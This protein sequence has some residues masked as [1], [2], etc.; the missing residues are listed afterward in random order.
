MFVNQYNLCILPWDRV[1]R[2]KIRHDLTIGDEQKTLFMHRGDRVALPR[3]YAFTMYGKPTRDLSTEGTAITVDSTIE[4][5]DQ[6]K[7]VMYDAIQAI[8]RFHGAVICAPCGMGKTVLG[9]YLMSVLKRKTLIITTSVELMKQWM[10]SI[11]EMTD[12]LPERIAMLGGIKRSSASACISADVIIAVVQSVTPETMAPVKEQIGLTIYD[13]VHHMPA[14]TFYQ[15]FVMTKQRYMLGL[16]ATPIRKDRLEKAFIYS[17]G[18]LVKVDDDRQFEINVFT[19]KLVYKA[20]KAKSFADFMHALSANATRT[21][22][23]SSLIGELVTML[24]LTG[25]LVVTHELRLAKELYFSIMRRVNGKKKVAIVHG[26][27]RDFSGDEDIIVSVYKYIGESI[28]VKGLNAIFMVTPV[29]GVADDDG[30]MQGFIAQ[31]I[32]RVKRD[33]STGLSRKIVFTFVD[34]YG[35]SMGMYRK[36]ACFFSQNGYHVTTLSCKL[37]CMG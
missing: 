26:K 9:I 8:M 36:Q 20:L 16:T 17:I 25:V 6:Q 18:P 28:S 10:A 35:F 31:V 33:A 15:R 24:G 14:E 13:E 22:F 32:G 34:P 11:V 4:L 27:C 3:Y 1:D 30:Q 2:E 19:I 5:R 12:L 21:R 37:Q 29:S 7:T 23:I